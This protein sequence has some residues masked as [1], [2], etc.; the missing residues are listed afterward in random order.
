MT[1]AVSPA[2]LTASPA[3]ERPKIRTTGLSSR[4]PLWRLERVIAKSAPFNAAA[5][6][7]STLFSRSQNLCS[8]AMDRGKETNAEARSTAGIGVGASGSGPWA[9]DIGQ[10]PKTERKTTRSANDRPEDLQGIISA[11]R[12]GEQSG[13]GNPATNKPIRE[14]WQATQDA[15]LSFCFSLKLR[16]IVHCFA[17]L[18]PNVFYFGKDLLFVDCATLHHQTDVGDR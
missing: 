18:C 5:A 4:P 9:T 3:V 14:S 11:C 15:T 17:R 12:L 13:R 7:K 16:S 1:P 2:K 8:L 6:K 10:M